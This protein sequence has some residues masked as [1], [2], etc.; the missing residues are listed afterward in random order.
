M[1]THIK[2]K[3]QALLELGQSVWLDHLHRRMTRSDELRA[4][5]EAG[6]RGMTSNP[7]IFEH[8]IANG[9]DYDDAVRRAEAARTDREVFEAIEIEDV[10][11]AADQFRGV[12]DSTDGGDGFVSIEIS[13]ALARDTDGS[14][15]EARRLWKAVDRPN[16]MIKIP[17][18]REGWGAIES[19]LA[20][21]ININITLLFSVEHYRAV[22][23][24]YLRALE[25]RIAQGLS[26][27]QLASVASVFVSR[28]DTEIDKR[29]AAGGDSLVALR[30]KVAI[31]SARL[32]YAAFLE[33]TQSPRWR[34]LEAKGARKQR[35]LWAS[36]GTK[37]PDYSDVLYVE[38]LIGPETI[39]TVPP[40]TL[41]LFEDH[42]RI[43]LTLDHDQIREARRVLDRLADG[44]IEF[45]D[46]NRTLEDEGIAKFAKSF[47]RLLHVIAGKRNAAP[48]AFSG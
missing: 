13:P 45:G 39:V 15:A 24:A 31:A 30:G 7:T 40:E 29:I 23:E 43:S 35:L 38:S 16:V 8:A 2:T 17:G 36:T 18:T 37:N 11:E 32:A 9:S 25:T 33:I 6:L 44:G 26:V 3:M 1:E 5:I 20:D 14:A 21:G 42:G 12:Y 48:V 22:T 34:A 47:D 19:C 27:E 28:V 46:V 10:R 41:K 4:L